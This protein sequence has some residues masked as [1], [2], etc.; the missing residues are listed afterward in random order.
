MMTTA[1]AIAQLLAVPAAAHLDAWH[2]ETRKKAVDGTIMLEPDAGASAEIVAA[3]KAFAGYEYHEPKAVEVCS[4]AGVELDEGVLACVLASE[5]RLTR[6]AE[7]LAGAHALLNDA[8][9]L[10]PS[11]DVGRGRAADAVLLRSTAHPRAHLRFGRQAGDGTARYCATFQPPT[12]RTLAAARLALAG[13]G[14]D[15]A[16]G[17]R[18][19]VDLRSQD[20]GRQGGEKLANDGESILR[21]R[22][23]E[24]LRL[25]PPDA[26]IDQYELALLGD[27]GVTLDAALE[28][29]RA[30]RA[31]FS[32]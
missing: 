2:W 32:R 23:T 6:P 26:R 8:T 4:G 10:F 29:L 27:R 24:G 12:L 19:W 16:Q 28:V 9:R 3:Y 30:G 15:L 25:V 20:G 18:R 14:A 1:Q 17:A 11:N 7:L 13:V 21:K 22:Y 5:F 31:R